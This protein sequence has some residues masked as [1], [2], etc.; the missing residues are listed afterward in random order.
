MVPQKGI[1]TP[2]AGVKTLSEEPK[3]AKNGRKATHNEHFLHSSAI[4][5]A[6]TCWLEWG[7]LVIPLRFS[8]TKRLL[9]LSRFGDAFLLLQLRFSGPMLA[10]Q[11]PI[12]FDI[13][14]A[15]VAN[16]RI[17]ESAHPFFYEIGVVGNGSQEPNHV[18]STA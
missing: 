6:R 14:P 8:F 11:S 18:E 5:S 2:Q 15:L 12:L 9:S 13:S 16:Y 1:Q 17:S 10:I 4:S 3:R 7:R